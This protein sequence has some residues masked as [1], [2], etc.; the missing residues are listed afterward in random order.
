M[1][2]LEFLCFFLQVS[3]GDIIDQFSLERTSETVYN[4]NRI[5]LLEI[6]ETTTKK[7]NL[8]I[9][10]YKKKNISI[11]KEDYRVEFNPEV[12]SY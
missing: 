11:D 1:F 2:F 4:F 12:N 9:K 8:K 5:Q 10:L 6:L 7:G 3:E